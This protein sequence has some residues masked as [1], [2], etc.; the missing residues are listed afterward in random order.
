ML[1]VREGILL[2][3][4][5]NKFGLVLFL[6]FFSFSVKAG[7]IDPASL[8]YQG[9][10]RLPSGDS[11]IYSGYALAFYPDGDKNGSPDGY[12]GSLFILGHDHHQLIAEIPIPK[13]IISQSKDVAQL[14]RAGI[15][16]NFVDIRPP[17]MFE[18]L[19]M[20]RAG[21]A[22]V[23]SP[24]EPPKLHFC[25]GQHNQEFEASHGLCSL[26]I[27]NPNPKGP[28]HFGEYTNYVTNDYLFDVPWGWA[29]KYAYM[30]LIATGRFR[31]GQ[32]GGQ[33]PTLF[34]YSPGVDGNHP[35]PK[36]KLKEI[37]PLILY[38]KQDQGAIEITNS[39]SMKLNNFKEAD[40]WSGG[41]WLSKEEDS[42]VIFAG[43]K[44]IGKCWYGFSNG[45]VWPTGG[46][47]GEVYPKVPDWPHDARGWWSEDIDAQIIFYDTDQLGQVASG[48]LDTWVPQP[49][50][51]LSIDDYLYDPGMDYELAKRYSLG[52][53]SFDRKNGILYIVERRAYEDESLV[54]VWKIK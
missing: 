26:D 23:Y 6:I 12:P 22:V 1:L 17:N 34:V 40:E 52:A 28:W 46:E 19:E 7:S 53:V 16:S 38:G 54:H 10:F 3:K 33:G 13:P 5:G 21:L 20:P 36:S 9:A 42:A 49:Y 11:W 24:E 30:K 8:K 41:S 32:W 29:D 15:L 50:A 27:S 37:T 25:W 39:D 2:M 47:E 45:V 18:Y 43:T 48:E 4:L 51:T 35:N 14:N 44:A 31:D